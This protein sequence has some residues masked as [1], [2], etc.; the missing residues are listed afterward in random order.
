LNQALRKS[1][2]NH[3]FLLNSQLTNPN[4]TNIN[5]FENSRFFLAKK[6]FFT[7]N[8]SNNLVSLY[9]KV[10]SNNYTTQ[11]A[12]LPTQ[13]KL[14]TTTY[15]NNL[16]YLI[17]NTS[18]PSLYAHVKTYNTV[19]RANYLSNL[20]TLNTPN[21]DIINSN[22]TQFFFILTSNL[23]KLNNT[24]YFNIINHQPSYSNYVQIKFYR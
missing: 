12:L 13:S 17:T 18:T 15:A 19:N 3:R 2:N 20:V 24:K 4:F 1:G 14:A 16:N 5:F 10:V 11:T 8:I 9:T 21:L 22:N 6:Y 23:S 7:N